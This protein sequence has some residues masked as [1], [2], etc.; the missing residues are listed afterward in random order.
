MSSSP[1]LPS[2]SQLFSNKAPGSRAAPGPAD[3]VA[4]F[5]SASLLRQAHSIDESA[6]PIA[7]KKLDLAKTLEVENDDVGP[8]KP[9]K[10]NNEKGKKPTFKRPRVSLKKKSVSGQKDIVDGELDGSARER[11]IIN[12]LAPMASRKKKGKEDGERQ[13][14]IKKAKVTK[15]GI[16]QDPK[17][18]KKAAT[19]KKKT[20]ET[21]AGNVETLAVA[22][23]SGA[24]AKEELQDLCLEKATRRRKA[25][26]PSKDTLHDFPHTK[27]AEQAVEA[28]LQEKATVNG[29]GAPQFGKLLGD[30][31]FAQEDGDSTIISV[32]PRHVDGEVVV[33]RRRIELVNGVSVPLQI[34]KSKRNKSPKKKPQTV[35]AKA[36]A[37]F[38]PARSLDT[39][40]LLQYFTTP[41]IP[42]QDP[43][44]GQQSHVGIDI[45]PKSPVKRNARLTS[46]ELKSK[47][48]TQ[49]PPNLLSPESA[50]K[51]A[52]NQELI[53]GTSSQLVREES[54]TFLKDLQQAM[55][56]SESI[57][58]P[59]SSIMSGMGP[60]SLCRSSKSLP[61]RSSRDLWSVAARGF[62]GSLLDAEM[63]NLA[64]TPKPR[65]I[66]NKTIDSPV[67]AVV[68]ESQPNPQG[69]CEV[70]NN[71]DD[72]YS[73]QKLTLEAAPSQILE[74]EQTMPRSIAEA[75]LRSRPKSRSPVK[76]A[77][78]PKP[79]PNQMPNY[80]GFTDLQLSKEVA[81]YRF[82]A[83]KKREAMI[84]LLERCWDSKTSMALQEIPPNVNLSHPTVE[85]TSGEIFKQGSP[86]KKRGRP[87]KFSTAT[88]ISVVSDA[89]LKK[90]RG[91]PKKNPATIA[92]P[93]K[94]KRKTSTPRKANAEAEAL[95][96][97]EIYD[98]SPP[99]PSP[100][101]RR[102][103][104]KSP[105]QL[106]LSQ[107][108]TA[109][110]SG[111]ATVTKDRAYLFSQITKAITTFPP[112]HNHKSLTWHEKM[113]MYEPVVL[114][115]LAAW[116]NT[117]GLNRVNVDNEVWP[118]LVKEW[119]EERSICC[120][121]RENLRGGV[122]GRY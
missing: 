108:L 71:V 115:D 84:S 46:T 81:S 9:W 39:S 15:P 69:A 110:A 32:A 34:E 37:P 100:P 31:G 63:V 79:G 61:P 54:P 17:K 2:L 36:T 10:S 99:T 85:N 18:S 3:A 76:K 45:R 51:T 70:W 92:A 30:F 52:G 121:W 111:T 20:K 68:L 7:F 102:S 87:P 28:R 50:L 113:L 95:A 21:V 105:G 5:A 38:V 53:F 58:E 47:K 33:K 49:K 72:V 122:R 96:A 29:P 22:K 64:D 82:K 117:V 19:T 41:A 48:Q 43:T 80:Q 104:P 8:A 6:S 120:L 56:E 73:T 14:K 77:S 24:R 114:E 109:T 93:A 107:P 83:I 90:P 42:S 91:R 74:L 4:G 11:G 118:G 26:T 55:K 101:R 75:A 1:S 60:L 97:D 116:L 67:A 65:S 119:C 57:E 89:P 86:S 103:P 44:G 27:V 106:P 35:T 112:S 25:W 78:A 13:T 88:N 62:D 94:R 16:A 23:E 12:T 40:S 66:H 98:S 59:K